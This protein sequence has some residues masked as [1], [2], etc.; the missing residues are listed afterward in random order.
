MKKKTRVCMY[1][2][3]DQKD[4]YVRKIYAKLVTNWQ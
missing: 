1:I 2:E 3:N 4:F